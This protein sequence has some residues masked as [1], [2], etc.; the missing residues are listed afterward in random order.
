MGKTFLVAL[1]N[2]LQFSLLL[3][4]LFYLF[5]SFFGFRR[6][7]APPRAARRRRF[8]VL[9]PAYN[10][11]GGI[12]LTVQSLVG[13]RYPRELFDVFVVADHCSD[14]TAARA[15][16]AGARVLEHAGPGLKAGKGRALKWAVEGLLA[17]GGY[18]AYCYFDADSL[19]HPDFLGAMNDALEAGGQVLQGRVLP[20]NHGNWISRTLASGLLVF[21]R[22]SQFPK[23]AAGLS[24]SLTGKGM[25]FTADAAARYRWDEAALTEDLEMQ[26]CVVRRGGRVLLVP[27]AVAYDEQPETLPQYV[28][29]SIRWTRGSLDVARR[30]LP[31]LLRQALRGDAAAAESSLYCLQSYKIGAGALAALLVWLTSG[32]FNLVTWLY[33]ALPGAELTMKTLSLVPLFVYPAASL[34]MERAAPE[35]ALGY[36]A[37]PVLGSL[38]VPVF[39]AGVFR[40][41]DFWGRTEH[42]SRVAIADLVDR[43][44]AP[45]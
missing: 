6:P 3:L 34:L 15:A 9:V 28:K 40:G 42:T 20:R 38:R 11:E 16:A 1:S 24:V 44:G 22:F 39:V 30:N 37:Q 8:A 27:G 4:G 25:C 23:H 26:M 17:A 33:A 5:L 19:A 36:L 13:M 43:S 18:D 7:A 32:S 14:A 31:A 12:A 41:N 21:G 10:E 35:L 29:R 45:L 2:T